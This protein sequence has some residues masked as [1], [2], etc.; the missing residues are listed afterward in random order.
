M[1]SNELF[2][3]KRILCAGDFRQLLPVQEGATDTEL[4]NLSVKSS[5][6]WKNFAVIHLTENMRAGIDEL[7]FLIGFL[8]W[9]MANLMMNTTW[10]LYQ[11]IV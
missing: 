1:D 10:L 3:G 2:G 11:K 9:G 5:Y 6:L 7:N 8:I 4:V